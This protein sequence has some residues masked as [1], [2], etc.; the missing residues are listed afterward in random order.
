[1]CDNGDVQYSCCVR[2][3]TDWAL[4]EFYKYKMHL[5]SKQSIPCHK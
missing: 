2:E 4:F 1:M 5:I 3:D